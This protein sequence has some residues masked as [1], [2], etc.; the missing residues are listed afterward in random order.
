M[1]D[2]LT[3]AQRSSVMRSVRQKDTAPERTVRSKI[4]GMGFRFRLHVRT[5]PGNP[6]IVL[7]RHR[8]II[9]VHGCFWHQHPGCRKATIPQSNRE[10]WQEK[11]ERNR[12]RDRQV[13]HDLRGQGWSVLIV[14][15]CQIR[16]GKKLENRLRRFL[17]DEHR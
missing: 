17:Y 3:P 4:H 14:W 12:S 7:P 13:L 16:D 15:E 10:F 5:L 9:L 2:R 11:L 6:D 1:T 8:K